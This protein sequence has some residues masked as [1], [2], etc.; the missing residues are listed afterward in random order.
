MNVHMT[1]RRSA[2]RLLNV[3]CTFN[4]R[5]VSRKII[6]NESR[7]IT[8]FVVSGSIKNLTIDGVNIYLFS[9]FFQ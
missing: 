3:L 5:P 2:G 4:L 9:T 8:L 1:F 6:V 7:Y